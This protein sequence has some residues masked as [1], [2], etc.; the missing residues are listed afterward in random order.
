MAYLIGVDLGGT[1]MEAAI[2]DKITFKPIER[3]RIPTDGHLGYQSICDRLAGL[4]RTICNKYN[5]F[6]SYVGIGTPGTLDPI[7]NEM[8]NCNATALN[9]QPLKD[10]LE[11]LLNMEVRLSNDANCFAVAEARL[12]I[13]KEEMPMA[14]VVFGVIMG[15]GVGGGIVV[16]G[17]VL[18]GRQGIG[19]EWG[20]NFLNEEGGLCFCGKIGCVEKVIAGPSLEKHYHSISGVK[21]KM[22][23]IV[24]NYR[25]GNDD[26]A[27]TTM[28]YLFDNFGRAISVIINILDPDA[29]VI[30]GGVGN[31]DELYTIGKERAKKYVL[32]NGRLDTMFLKPKLGDSAGVFGA[33]ML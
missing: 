7:T 3:M 28:E 11:K 23:Q 1:K 9:G 13:V 15:T 21:L 17:K 26:Y 24:E 31:I 30:G 29:I 8:K 18:N 5:F 14:K 6:P 22:P 4:I 16:D 33:A 32:N 12:G 10:D 27:N 2:L 20:H 25:S 19:G